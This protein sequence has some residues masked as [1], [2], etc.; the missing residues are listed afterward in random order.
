LLLAGTVVGQLA[1]PAAA[2]AIPE[3]DLAYARLLVGVE[4]LASDYYTRAIAS[5]RFDG[6][7][8]KFLKRARFNEREHYNAVAQILSGAGQAP[9]MAADVDFSYPRGSFRS[10]TSIAKLGVTLE[11]AFLGTYLGAVAGLQTNVLKQP[12]SGIA[13]S[14]AQ[15]LSLLTQIAGRNPVGV[16]FPSPLAVDEASN[17][18]DAFTS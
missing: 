8:L 18:L 9:A 11:S 4:L 14:E 1:G 3:E 15:H 7:A 5:K 16:S 6:N 2:D 17:V 10:K 13:A 12:I